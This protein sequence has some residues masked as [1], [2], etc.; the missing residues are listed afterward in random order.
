LDIAFGIIFMA[1]EYWQIAQTG[2][3]LEI[4]TEVENENKRF[5][6]QFMINFYYCVYY[7][8]MDWYRT[9]D[10]E[11]AENYFNII[12]QSYQDIDYKDD[13]E[14]YFCIGL[15]Y[16]SR[17]GYY[18]AFRDDTTNVIKFQKKHNEA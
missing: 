12:E 7:G 15:Y 17:P 16:F 11:Q 5:K 4:L 9:V 8:S 3:L 1:W 13:W 10:K 6:D 2:K 18:Y 14:K